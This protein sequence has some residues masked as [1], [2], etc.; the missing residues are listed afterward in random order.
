MR[1]SKPASSRFGAVRGMVLAIAVA[2][3]TSSQLEAPAAHAQAQPP[4]A[5]A[6]APAGGSF[7]AVRAQ[8]QL[9]GPFFV[10]VDFED[11]FAKLGRDLTQAVSDVVGDDPDLAPYRQD[12]GAILDELG[13]SGIRAIGMSSTLRRDGSYHNRSFLHAP[14]PRRG[15]LAAMGG[16]ARP[17][18]TTRLAPADTDFFLEAEIDMPALVQAI[19]SVARR[20]DPKADIDLATGAIAAETGIDAGDAIKA[21]TELRGRVTFFLRLGETSTPDAARLEE[22]ALGLAQKGGLLLRV[23]GI[24]PKLLPMLAGIPELAPATIAGRRAFRGSETVPILG[25]NQPVLVVDGDALVLASSAA[26]AEQSLGRGA[27]L[28]EAPAFRDALAEL[29]VDQ[30]NSLA[31]ATPRLYRV[32]RTL[33]GAAME[34]GSGL[35]AD[36]FSGPVAQA[37]L[38]RMPDLPSPMVQVAANLPDGIL[39]RAHGPSSLK[40]GLLALGLYNP[41]LIGPVALALVPAAVKTAADKA[42]EGRAAEIAQANLQAIGEAALEW[43]AANPSAREVGYAD[44]ARALEGRLR[45]VKDVDFT[46]FTLERGFSKVEL[47][48]P[49]G[50]TVAWYA[51]IT[52]ADR[53]RIR[54]NLRGFDRAAAWY[55]RKYPRETVMLG[56]EAAEDGSPMAALPDP[57]RDERYEDLQIRRTDTAIEIEVGAETIAIRRDPALQR[58]QQQPQ[59]QRRQPPRGG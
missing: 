38:G 54:E 5:T 44:I 15:L 13:I 34:S 48:L 4:A 19:V 2:A 50:E 53:E 39:V 35:G 45:R 27:G 56:I 51:P 52:E 14:G 49:S 46:D 30:G 17:F 23:E 58:Q 37:I 33:L 1:I 36:A 40:S 47:E 28:A 25:E 21:I 10:H 3:S 26:F 59:Q 57:V 41:E 12:F 32:L 55:F 42:S 22:W 11:Q 18:A 31:Y 6:P 20:F 24:A 8:L 43:F 29:G 16:P 7:E 9:G